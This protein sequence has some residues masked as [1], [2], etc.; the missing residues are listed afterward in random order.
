MVDRLPS[1]RSSG[2]VPGGTLGRVN[3]GA[4][5][6]AGS[7][8]QQLGNAVQQVGQAATRQAVEREK[9]FHRS[10]QQ[11][12]AN[13]AYNRLNQKW[14]NDLEQIK[15]SSD[16]LAVDMGGAVA[17]TTSADIAQALD[18]AGDD[19]VFRQ[20]LTAR[21]G[22]LQ[23]SFAK[24][25]LIYETR[26]RVDAKGLEL[27][28]VT[29]ANLNGII[30]DGSSFDKFL[31]DSINAINASEELNDL[32]KQKLI[33]A[34]Q[35]EAASVYYRS[36]I[37]ADP[38]AV[39][40][41]MAD[42]DD[43]RAAM[44]QPSRRVALANDAQAQIDR[45]QAK[46]E[47]KQGAAIRTAVR[48]F[49]QLYDIAIAT[50]GGAASSVQLEEEGRKIAAMP[51]SVED[52]AEARRVVQLRLN[53]FSAASAQAAKPLPD[54]LNQIQAMVETGLED[55]QS[56]NNYFAALEVTK[57]AQKAKEDG[58]Q[59]E[60]LRRTQ[61]LPEDPG[62]FNPNDAGDWAQQSLDADAAATYFGQKRVS[63]LTPR[64]NA[65]LAR[66]FDEGSS[67]DL[68][69]L[70][71]ALHQGF[72]ASGDIET[73]DRIMDTIGASELSPNISIALNVLSNTGNQ[74]AAAQVLDAAK[75]DDETIKS[76]PSDSRKTIHNKVMASA[77]DN[78]TMLGSLFS[79]MSMIGEPSDM[80]NWRNGYAE[81]TNLVAQYLVATGQS[82]VENA[83][84][85]AQKMLW[86]SYQT[87][88]DADL[89]VVILT[90]DSGTSP[91]R[92]F[93][94]MDM[95]RQRIS[96]AWLDVPEGEEPIE[97][98]GMSR[99]LYEEHWRDL[100]ESGRYAPGKH[101]EYALYHPTTMKAVSEPDGTDI[102]TWSNSQLGD[103]SA[104]LR[105]RT[106]VPTFDEEFEARRQAAIRAQDQ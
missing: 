53:T 2:T 62:P 25:S 39:K 44:L 8:A 95:E 99:A 75:M 5:G 11:A 78:S 43:D 60:H 59:I 28:G 29:K 64:L 18:S 41:D 30:A 7:G 81:G 74:V 31:G 106:L 56:Q 100:G 91:R 45:D 51:G 65:A 47:V 38:H 105:S 14:T 104:S 92:V 88:V 54:Q 84:D 16:P 61:V 67:T 3:V 52:K 101:G 58:T 40:A 26:Q 21:L 57:A 6:L 94:G 23:T 55:E 50:A 63:M 48:T 79:S 77:E 15:Q 46:M 12:Y 42:P 103:I 20:E 76:I 87:A 90:P 82:T 32:Q 97:F 85:D 33:V 70:Y 27:A 10:N 72:V 1:F 98:Q 66:Q 102:S 34:T 69:Q 9:K 68:V 13:A 93:D 86:G 19:P 24:Q 17:A 96:Q 49:D 22:T 37:R 83:A 35:E 36:L 89:G 80:A 73:W 71:G 4:A